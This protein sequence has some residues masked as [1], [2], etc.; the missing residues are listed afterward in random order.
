MGAEKFFSTRIMDDTEGQEQELIIL[1]PVLL[2]SE[3]F[4]GILGR[5][6]FYGW[7]CYCF[8]Q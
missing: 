4:T 8:A 2:A 7:D 3:N 1:I 6:G 5:G